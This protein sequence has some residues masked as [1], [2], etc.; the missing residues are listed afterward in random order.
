MKRFSRMLLACLLAVATPVL[1][2]AP[3][4]SW[5][6][7][8]ALKQ[9]N[10]QADD[11]DT[12]LTR[13]ELVRRNLDGEETGR[14][15]AVIFMDRSG[16]VR[17]D[18]AEPEERTYLVLRS[19]LYIHFPASERVEQYSLSRHKERL[20]PFIRL[21][22]SLTGKDLERDY[23][24]TSLGERDIGESRTLG[25]ALTPKSDKI[26]EV[27]AG[28]KL[29]I[30]QASWLPSQ[31]VITSTRT[32]EELEVTYTHSARNLKLNPD[33]FKAKWPRGTKKERM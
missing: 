26:R 25:L 20:E 32:G 7:D 9:I 23:L 11:F 5:D 10:R 24:L 17:M 4:I 30:D 6:L 27:V 21:G 1:G 19:D 31:Q 28:I 33:L 18:V 8:D 14:Q 15:Q 3:V 29:W 2:Q 12:V 22:F 16:Q 13:A